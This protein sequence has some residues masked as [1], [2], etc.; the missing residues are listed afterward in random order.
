MAK[1]QCPT[2]LI[3]P[4]VEP[5]FSPVPRGFGIEITGRCQLRCR[6]CYNRS[7]PDSPHELPLQ[8]IER[9]LEESL[10]WGVRH[11]RISGG[12]PTL[13][14]RFPEV[15]EACRRRG[16][17]V[18]M[19]TNGIYTAQTMA[20][21]RTAPLGRLLVSLDGLEASH[22]AIRGPG[23]FARAVDSCRQLREAGQKVTVSFHAGAGNRSD[24]EGLCALA[25]GIGADFKV[26]QI[27]PI[28]RAAD[29]LPHALL[30][31]RD[32]LEVATQVVRLR[33]RFPQIRI[34]T[35]FDIL[36]P[37]PDGACG[38]DPSRAS[39]MAGRTNVDVHFD[40]SIYP[41]SF[42]AT[43]ERQFSA[44]SVYEQS[45]TQ[46]WTSSPVF[47]PFR[48]H[49]KSEACQGCAHYQVQCKRGCPAVA[50]FATGCLDALDPT[51]FAH[52]VPPQGDAP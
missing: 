32:Y 33:R 43:P 42:F 17:G 48:V 18:S 10:Q 47:E 41:C 2:R 26:S 25:A 15:L 20:H 37:A 8:V 23:T 28:G 4:P 27:R 52:L 38:R 51:C 6:H 29:E 7:G 45:V 44:G 22:E 35:D 16:I 13:H 46:A 12:E 31:P 5:H 49:R 40:G 30:E 34:L 1:H 3:H 39:C 19:N 36:G 50:H 14:R 9:L 11:A 24:M 21:L